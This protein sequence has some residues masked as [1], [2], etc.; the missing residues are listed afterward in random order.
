MGSTCCSPMCPQN[1]RINTGSEG[2]EYKQETD[3]RVCVRVYQTTRH[4]IYSVFRPTTEQIF[5]RLVDRT[6]IISRFFA[7]YLRDGHFQENNS[8]A[9]ILTTFIA[10]ITYCTVHKGK[11]MDGSNINDYIR[12]KNYGEVGNLFVRALPDGSAVEF[13]E[14]VL[15]TLPRNGGLVHKKA[16]IST[17]GSTSASTGSAEALN[18]NLEAESSKFVLDDTVDDMSI[19]LALQIPEDMNLMAYIIGPKGINVINIG[20]LSGTKIQLEKVGARGTDQ[21]RHIFMMGPLKCV[22]RAYQVM[23]LTSSKLLNQ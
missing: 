16:R 11:T 12:T 13:L 21:F 3:E 15:S 7:K 14:N 23:L 20:K 19:T 1:I 9:T 8:C 10:Q 2:Y 17:G 6:S 22:L 18:A 4:G 5:C